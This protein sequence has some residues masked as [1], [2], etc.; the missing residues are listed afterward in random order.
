MRIF[1][2]FVQPLYE[3]SNKLKKLESSNKIFSI[4]KRLASNL[5]DVQPT[6]RVMRTIQAIV[7]GCLLFFI[8]KKTLSVAINLLLRP[9][10]F[11]PS[12]FPEI[13]VATSTTQPPVISTMKGVELIKSFFNFNQVREFQKDN[14][15]Q[16]IS[17]VVSDET[18][19]CETNPPFTSEEREAVYQAALQAKLYIEN[20]SP[21]NV[22]DLE[23]ITTYLKNQQE[24][25]FLAA[26]WKKSH[27]EYTH[28]CWLFFSDVVYPEAP[29]Q[30]TLKLSPTAQ[31]IRGI[32][33]TVLEARY[34]LKNSTP[35][36]TCFIDKLDKYLEQD[37]WKSLRN[38]TE[39]SN[40]ITIFFSST[41]HPNPPGNYALFNRFRSN[42]AAL[43]DHVLNS[44]KLNEF[45]PLVLIALG[46][47][48]FKNKN[49]NKNKNL[50]SILYY[51]IGLQRMKQDF[52]IQGFEDSDELI[53]K[54]LKFNQENINQGHKPKEWSSCI[55][56]NPLE[57]E[58]PTASHYDPEDDQWAFCA[59]V[60]YNLEGF[61]PAE[62]LLPVLKAL[63]IKSFEMKKAA[64]P[65]PEL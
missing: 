15:L 56:K 21:E 48:L 34:Q 27:T 42:P 55:K 4:F 43:A 32:R 17:E 47:Y 25:G 63:Q 60:C 6:P 61:K 37:L 45:N 53:K 50:K 19:R 3:C 62:T 12:L 20:E 2:L 49:K 52:K 41:C 18:V 33:E 26:I 7:E 13:I 30:L 64:R 5:N 23:N 16:L 44:E 38:F 29:L 24:I 58:D 35:L 59:K 39:Q 8:V 31:E 51:Q 14:I 10:H 11:V 57:N 1:N 28:R 54:I 65:T 9:K 46:F 36:D 22:E 40:L